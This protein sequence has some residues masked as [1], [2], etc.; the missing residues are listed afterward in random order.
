MGADYEGKETN[1]LWASQE[2]AKMLSECGGTQYA[3]ISQ[4]Y[5]SILRGFSSPN[6]LSECGGRQYA[7]TVSLS[8]HFTRL[9]LRSASLQLGLEA[10]SPAGCG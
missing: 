4:P 1:E 3:S 2:R 10:K 9:F 5:L 7:C 8:Q 6:A